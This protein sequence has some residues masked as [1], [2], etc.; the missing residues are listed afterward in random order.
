MRPFRALDSTAYDDIGRLLSITETKCSNHGWPAST[1][2]WSS[3]TDYEQS[4]PI[5]GVEGERGH[6]LEYAKR[7]DPGCMG[8]F[9]KTAPRLYFEFTSDSLHEFV[10][11]RVEVTTLAFSEYRGG[12]FAEKEAWYDILLIAPRGREDLPPGTEACVYGTRTG[13]ACGS[14]L[15]K[16]LSTRRPASAPMGEYR[17]DIRF[18][19]SFGRQDGDCQHWAFQDRCLTGGSR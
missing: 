7:E 16:L 11:E 10:L 2:P 15:D 17:I 19:F 13:D 14:G 9:M 4:A 12:G 6:F 5:Q 8:Q 18:V 3:G 1:R